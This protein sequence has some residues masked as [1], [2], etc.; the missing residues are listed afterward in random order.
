[1]KSKIKFCWLCSKKLYGNHS[2][3]LVIDTHSRTLHKTCAKTIGEEREY[4]KDRD[5]GYHSTMWE[6]PGGFTD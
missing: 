6:M 1:M 3:V 5:G 4:R 2:E